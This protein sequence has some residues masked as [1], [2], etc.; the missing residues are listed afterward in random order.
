MTNKSWAVTLTPL[1]IAL[2]QLAEA[3]LSGSGLTQEK[4]VVFIT[5]LIA[6]V[7]SGA[8]GASI[9]KSKK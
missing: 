4:L 9:K 8:I 2:L 6:F 3:Y 7:S 1:L 5:A